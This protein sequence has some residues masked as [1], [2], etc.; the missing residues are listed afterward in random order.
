MGRKIVRI[1][2]RI[3][4]KIIKRMKR[5]FRFMVSKCPEDYKDL[6]GEST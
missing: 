3:L 4:K 6:C 2:N 1:N 5:S